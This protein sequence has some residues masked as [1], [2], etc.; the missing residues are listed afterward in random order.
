MSANTKNDPLTGAAQGPV[1]TINAYILANMLEQMVDD[2]KD[3]QPYQDQALNNWAMAATET[4]FYGWIW[5][6]PNTW[7]IIQWPTT[8][9]GRDNQRIHALYA[10]I[11][12]HYMEQNGMSDLDF[13]LA[14]KYGAIELCTMR[15]GVRPGRETDPQRQNN[16]DQYIELARA[17]ARAY[18]HRRK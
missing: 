15:V 9:L 5:D 16:S 18:A 8:P 11:K 2:I 17:S 7:V 4:D 6:N 1:Q 14:A 13:R 12:E 10:R 3:G